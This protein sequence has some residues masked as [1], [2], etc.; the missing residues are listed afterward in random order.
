MRTFTLY[1][2]LLILGLLPA[3]RAPIKNARTTEVVING[4]CDM[5]EEN[6]ETAALMEGV[7]EVDWDKD[8][9][10]A[11]ITY[12]SA[13]TSVNAV[14]QRIANAGYDNQAFIAPDSAYQELPLCCR[15]ERTGKVVNPPTP[16]DTRHA[17]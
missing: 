14:L 5:C 4:N 15:Y 8:T 13:R 3:C 10:H 7:S 16:D 1:L 17:H 6:I 9:R 12:D 2:L 11:T